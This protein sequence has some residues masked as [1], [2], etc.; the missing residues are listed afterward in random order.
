MNPSSLTNYALLLLIIYAPLTFATCRFGTVSGVNFGAYNVFTTTPDNSIGSI[1]IICAPR[2]NVLVTLSTGQS[3][4]FTTR[5]L[6]S[7]ANTINYNLYT[8][9]TYTSIWGDGTGVSS[10]VQVQ[11][12]A[13]TTLN[14]YGQI[15]A[16]QDVAIGSYTD[17]ITVTITF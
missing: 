1:Q 4:A 6:K 14:I 11:N 15:P 5:T 17:N 10:S 9:S 13:S 8:D 3:G 2:A 16:L 12:L 7:G